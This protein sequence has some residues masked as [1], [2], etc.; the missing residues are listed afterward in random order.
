MTYRGPPPASLGLGCA[1]FSTHFP[2]ANGI[3]TVAPALYPAWLY[4]GSSSTVAM[5]SSLSSVVVQIERAEASFAVLQ[6]GP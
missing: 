1:G 6:L 3:E 2:T 5:K 4:L